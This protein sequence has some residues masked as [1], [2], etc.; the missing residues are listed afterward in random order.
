MATPPQVAVIG[1]GPAGLYAAEALVK[2]TDGDVQVD[3][4]DRLPTPYG[5][6]RYGV[7]PDHKSIK[8]IARYLQRVLEGAGV[9]FFGEMELGRD[10]SRADL[11]ECYDAVIYST[12]AMVDRQLGIPGEN[13]PGSVA[14]TDFVNWY[15]GHPDAAHH[16]FDLTAREVAV[17]GVGNV[18]VD[19]VRILAKTPEELRDTDVPEQ[20]LEKLAQSRVER[21][22]MIGR[23][24]PAQAKFTTKEARELGEL[25]NASIHVLPQ[26]MDLDP[27]SATVAEND[28]HVR[29]NVKV[30]N[31][32][33]GEP[34]AAPRRIDVRF[35]LAPEEI[36]GT[37]QVE[38]LK[39][40]RTRLDDSGRVAGTGEYETLPV[41]MVL[42]SVGY[43]SVPLDGVPFDERYHVVP[44]E[45]GRI[46][47]S[48]GTQVLREYVAGWIKRGPTG[49]VGTNKSDA[50]ETVKNLLAD[51]KDDRERPS[52]T[53][54][55]L[56]E[57]RGLPVVTYSDW[58]NLDAAEIA[59]AR[60][61]NRGERVKLAHW[62]AMRNAIRPS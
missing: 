57:S 19:V 47:D 12:G 18:A 51:L 10:L 6:V 50:A 21:I 56:L 11:L 17:I 4:F 43:Q 2:Q 44:N 35:W 41:G 9:R 1:S 8:S 16:D 24:G 46:L 62:E 38:G 27:A 32:W 61:L 3:V 59:L 22:H 34:A 5:L 37:A 36:L 52:R 20:V 53:I 15:C 23:R 60:S 26:D 48:D 33:T 30:L 28:R 54:E 49:V 13:L 55:E 7:A 42:R 14:A 31:G 58:L 39:L 29:G 40:E 45:G 25:P